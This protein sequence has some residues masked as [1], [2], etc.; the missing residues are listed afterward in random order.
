MALR[1]GLTAKVVHAMASIAAVLA[2]AGDNDRSGLREQLSANR[3]VESV[4]VK[5]GLRSAAAVVEVL[6]WFEKTGSSHLL[7]VLSS[8]VE[9]FGSGLQRLAQ[10]AA[11]SQAAIVY[12][13][14]FDR[15]ADG[16]KL[17]PLIDYQPGSIRDDF[18]FGQIV[19]LSR[20]AITGVADAIEHERTSGNFGG[21][22]DLRLRATERGAVV[23]LAEPTYVVRAAV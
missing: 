14:Y 4:A 1:I 10:V 2:S 13:D 16:I 21:W 3:L 11:D 6:R 8:R 9:L 20:E 15:Q 19:L 23:H 5:P 18:D 22:Y 12:S 17:H 7:W